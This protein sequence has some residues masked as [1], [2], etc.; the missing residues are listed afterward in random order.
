VE[1]REREREREM[2][3]RRRGSGHSHKAFFLNRKKGIRN[4]K[5]IMWQY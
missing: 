1:E 4:E 2:D 3:R 5:K